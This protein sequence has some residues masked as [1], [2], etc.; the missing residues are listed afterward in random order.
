MRFHLLVVLFRA[1]APVQGGIHMMNGVVSVVQSYPVQGLAGKVPG[2]VSNGLDVNSLLHSAL[3]NN[4][5]AVVLEKIDSDNT[6]LAPEVGSVDEQKILPPVQIGKED[7]ES[8]HNKVLNGALYTVRASILQ[9]LPQIA[10][11]SLQHS[12]GNS[13][14]EKKQ[15]Q[16]VPA[17]LNLLSS[18]DITRSLSMLVVRQVMSGH[19][20]ADR[21]PVRETQEHLKDLVQSPVGKDAA[22]HGVVS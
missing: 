11:V 10:D 18:H 22:M 12:R 21:M 16:E 20:R 1:K 14:L 15:V 3:F 6:V 19:I 4:I 7:F 9:L 17:M 5:T 8:Y 2:G 13:R